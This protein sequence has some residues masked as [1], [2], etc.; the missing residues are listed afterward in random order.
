VQDRTSIRRNIDQYRAV[1]ERELPSSVRF[2]L[3]QLLA[4]EV[5]KLDQVERR[6]KTDQEVLVP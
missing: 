5:A 2:A 1:L 6:E 3:R 4:D